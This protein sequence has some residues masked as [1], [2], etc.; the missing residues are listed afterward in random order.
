MA[1]DDL[2]MIVIGFN[3]GADADE[4]VGGRIIS[5]L[6]AVPQL[7]CELRT[8]EG[9]FAPDF[10]ASLSADTLV[11]FIDSIHSN[12]APGT[13]HCLKLPSRSVR[14]RHLDPGGVGRLQNEID[15][16]KKQN[17]PIPKLFLIGVEIAPRDPASKV[18]EPTRKAIDEIVRN[19]SRYLKLARH[20][21][22]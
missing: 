1:Q 7:D 2:T 11:I 21:V 19:F 17:A 5:E 15:E 20:L 12:S 8:V 9:E 4:S 14:P 16:L 22:A 10:L 13:V 6:R 3:G 18:S